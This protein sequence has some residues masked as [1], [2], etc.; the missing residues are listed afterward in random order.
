[1]L[2][3]AWLPSRETRSPAPLE[4]TAPCQGTIWWKVWWVQE[5]SIRIAGDAGMWKRAGMGCGE[6]RDAWGQRSRCT[7]TG[8]RAGDGGS[9]CE[10]WQVTPLSGPQLPISKMEG[11]ERMIP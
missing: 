5:S 7:G 10:L 11:L 8:S 3:S 1:M 4:S 6:A 9:L 2:G